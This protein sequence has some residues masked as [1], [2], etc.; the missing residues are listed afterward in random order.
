MISMKSKQ[1]RL[2]VC[3]CALSVLLTPA[4]TQADT[5]ILLAAA[6]TGSIAARQAA[7]Q[8]A[9]LAKKAAEREARKAAEEQMPTKAGV[10]VENNAPAEGQKGK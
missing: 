10:P 2:A 1:S 8:K 4:L 6:E 9:A 5:G 3:L 7:D